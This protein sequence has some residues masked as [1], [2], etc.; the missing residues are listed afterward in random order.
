MKQYIYVICALCTLCGFTSCEKDLEVYSEPTCRLNFLYENVETRAQFDEKLATTS[1]S[2]VYG[3]S[4]L[5]NDTLWFEVETMGFTSDKDRPVSLVQVSTGENDAVPSKHYVAFND[6]S[7][8]SKYVIP[9]GKARA[10]LPIVL[11]R[12]ASLQTETVTLKLSIQD[13]EYFV[14]GYPEFQ[15][16]TITFTDQL[17]EPSKW[18]A[19]ITMAYNY[20][21]YIYYYTTYFY[22]YFGNYGVVKHRFLIEKTGKAWDD[23]YIEELMGGDSNYIDYIQKKVTKLLE[24][25]NARRQAQGLDVLKEADGTVVDFND[26][27]PY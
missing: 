11:L 17:A 15:T 13:N 27:Y 21:G 6:P 22:Y 12:D 7:L 23:D 19:P 8:A 10:K 1:Y 5:T 4:D 14:Q 25:E 9:A 18:T 24:E 3:P 26:G 2:F 16:R 20:S